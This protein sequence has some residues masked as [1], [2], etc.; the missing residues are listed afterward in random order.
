MI[1]HIVMLNAPASDELSL[2][3]SSLSA[4]VGQI[5]GFVAFEHGPNRDL[6]GKSPNHPYGFIG[7][8][9]DVAAVAKYAEDP[10]HRLL[11]ARLVALCKGGADG[12]VVYDI[13]FTI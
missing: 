9:V 13:E 6:E 12:I 1:R 11:G 7:T 8:Y 4:L 2:V 3:M 5:D 10:R